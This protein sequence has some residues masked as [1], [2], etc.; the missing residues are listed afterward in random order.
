[1]RTPAVAVTTLLLLSACP[2][3][4]PIDGPAGPIRPEP[5]ERSVFIRA[6]FDQDPSDFLG[7]FLPDGIPAENI[8][9]TA[10]RVSSRCGKFL[11]T[12]TMK[13]SGSFEQTFNASD[14]VKGSL[15]VKPFG[16]LNA[17]TTG[18]AGLL[19]KYDMTEKMVVKVSD[20]DAFAQ[21]CEAAPT[22]CGALMIGEFWRG[23]GTVSQFAGRDND[24]GIKGSKGKVDAE[25][26]Y[27]DGWAW[28]RV[29]SFTDSYFAFRTAAGPEKSTLCQGAWTEEIPQSLDGKYFVGTASVLAD[30]AKA[31]E[32]ALRNARRDV[33][34]YLGE[35]LTETYSSESSAIEGA[36][37]DDTLVNAAAAGV[38]DHVKD[39]CWSRPVV[40]STPEG[41]H[42]E[43]K[44]L[45]FF[46]NGQV[47]PAE[48]AAVQT[49][50]KEAVAQKKPAVAA[51]LQKVAQR[52]AE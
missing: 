10:A 5:P 27:K 23:T 20:P 32:I 37:S 28:K 24:A 51:K 25:L 39:R 34:K 17:S 47:K 15:G 45:A 50:Q 11:T 26:T 29:S 2:S 18:K 7:R 12:K 41:P 13:A 49:M 38:A 42:T 16:A 43:I 33:V 1:M 19:V 22:E 46:P 48:V 40:T 30:E 21:C 52:L 14:N 31:R 35:K 9:E 6:S 8:D 4:S 36:I 44:V 3:P